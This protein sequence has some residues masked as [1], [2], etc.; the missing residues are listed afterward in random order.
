MFRCVCVSYTLC[1]VV[2]MCMDVLDSVSAWL[3]VSAWKREIEG[4]RVFLCWG[5]RMGLIWRES[6]RICEY[7]RLSLC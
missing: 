6:D 1:D 2:R 4:S 5:V 7:T 3:L